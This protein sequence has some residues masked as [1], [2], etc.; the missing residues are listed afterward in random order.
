MGKFSGSIAASGDD[1]GNVEVAG[2]FSNYARGG[3][4]LLNSGFG[5]TTSSGIIDIATANSGTSGVSGDMDLSTG[6]SA[7]GNSGY[8][9]IETGL[10]KS[11]KGGIGGGL[12]ATRL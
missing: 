11:G 2:G 3:A 8:I 9:N 10:A 12:M 6:T 5:Q 1:G 4:F 7:M